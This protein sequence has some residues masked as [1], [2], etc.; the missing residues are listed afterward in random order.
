MTLAAL[1]DLGVPRAVLDDAVAALGLGGVELVVRSGYAGA[2]GCTHVDVR[3]TAGQPERSYASIRELLAGSA[4]APAVREL[5]ERIFARLARA[6]AEV[7]RTTL[8]AVHFHEVG[9]VDALVDVVGSAALLEHLG[10]RVVG[11]SVPLGRGFVECRHGVLPL[12]APATLLALEGVPT[13]PSGL[14]VELVTPTG[15]A[16]L[17][18]CALCF[19]EW[20]QLAIQRVGWGAGTRGLS[21]R[22]NALR[23]VLG[24][25]REERPREERYAV[26][27]ANVDDMTGELAAHAL[28]ELLAAGALDAWLTPIT[29]KK[30]RPGLVV[31]ALGRL[32][33]AEALAAVLLRETTSIGV[34]QTVV[35]RFEL[36][37]R[38]ELVETRFGPVPFKLSGEP[39]TTCKPEFDACASIAARTGLPLRQVLLEVGEDARAQGR[40]SR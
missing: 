36:P 35:T 10:A 38:V 14:E 18:E 15:A 2:I 39:P 20:P 34:R 12:P 32:A 33:Q 30:G 8:D 1:L 4:L 19:E 11:S 21:D 37:R 40:S 31:A 9:A 17:A 29:M 26:L 7:H 23:A 16:I 25:P 5:A 13:R 28:T 6:E 24:R 27:E 22:P 3:V